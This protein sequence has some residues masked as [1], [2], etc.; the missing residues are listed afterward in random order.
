MSETH[1][2]GK[3]KFISRR[4]QRFICVGY[5]MNEPELRYFEARKEGED[6]VAY[7]RFMASTGSPYGES[8][9]AVF[10]V[11][12]KGKTAE[13]FCKEPRKGKEFLFDLQ[14]RTWQ[15][16]P[17]EGEKYG[18]RRTEFTGGFS[19]VGPKVDDRGTVTEP[20]APKQI[21]IEAAEEAAA[22]QAEK[23]DEDVPF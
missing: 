7:C 12:F 21:T 15:A 18:E 14:L 8:S 13:Y 3:K 9:D 20:A 1:D 4:F 5:V 11:Q 6:K 23:K 2:T 19:Y 16:P 22:K 17:K 10:G